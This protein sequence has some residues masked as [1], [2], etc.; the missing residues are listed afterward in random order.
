MTGFPLTLN[1]ISAKDGLLYIEG[2]SM[3]QIAQDFG[4]PAYVLS[5]AAIRDKCKSVREAFTDR[6][7]EAYAAYAGKALLTSALVRIIDSEGL[8]LDVVSGGELHVALAAGFP[9]ER[10]LFHGNNKSLEELKM[11]F[12]KGVGRI[13]VDNLYE[14]RALL[15]LCPVYNRHVDILLRITPGVHADTHR[16]IATGHSGSKFGF[17]L[18]SAMLTEALEDIAYQPLIRLLGFH[19]HVGSQ[20]FNHE[21]HLNAVSA[22]LELVTAV[23]S[24]YEIEIEELNFGGGFAVAYTAEDRPQSL[25]HF[26]EPIVERV[27][28]HYAAQSR[29][30]PRLFIEPGRYIVAEAGVTLYTTSQEKRVSETVTYLSTDGGMT[31]NIRPALYGAVYSALPVKNPT[32]PPTH[33]VTLC[34]KCCES[35]D[36]LI[37]DL[38]VPD[39][40]QDAVIA[41]FSTGAYTYPLA[42]HYNKHPH[43]PIVLVT[44]DRAEAI[45]ARET[46][47]DL[48][49]LDAIPK[50]LSK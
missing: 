37:S 44:G 3:A 8:Y 5:E 18:G 36:I 40:E 21:A 47:A 13:I 9:A 7:S 1:H 26:T 28:A 38:K 23:E 15:T 45:V 14:L 49:R 11:A 48:L 20:L 24:E 33:T 12:E 19:M 29:Q 32:A 34:G 50:H 25:S 17:P 31:D 6:H 39:M 43:P 27:E 30:R 41:V 46:Y 22:C 16:Y 4:T 42:S 35:G 10:I 2:C